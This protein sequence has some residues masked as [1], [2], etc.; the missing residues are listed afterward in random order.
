LSDE[1][2]VELLNLT[3]QKEELTSISYDQLISHKVA[4]GH[5]FYQMGKNKNLLVLKAGDYI[6]R[7]YLKKFDK[8]QDALKIYTLIDHQLVKEIKKELKTLKEKDYF[9][10]VTARKRII[11]FAKMVFSTREDVLD[12]QYK[13]SMLNM[14][15]AFSDTFNKLDENIIDEIKDASLIMYNRGWI[16]STLSVY[17]SLILG[18][19]DFETL[20]DIFNTS[21][22][23]DYGLIDKGISISLIDACERERV[24]PGAGLEFLKSK[25]DLHAEIEIFK[26]H[27]VK[28]YTKLEKNIEEILFNKNNLRIIKNHHYNN[29]QY[30]FSNEDYLKR[31]MSWEKCIIFADKI[32][33]YQEY[34]YSGD[35]C[36]KVFNPIFKKINNMTISDIKNDWNSEC[37]KQVI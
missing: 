10:K 30:N 35:D 12:D 20:S 3:I 17:F 31:K 7:E 16:L 27:P 32:L 13:K 19:V 14:V 22:L 36:V 21:F 23:M 24:K 25:K 15:V 9:A 4:I 11:Q 2:H 28:S 8:K 5:V 18:I 33:P 26:L 34:L 1:I 6:N 29:N 37:L